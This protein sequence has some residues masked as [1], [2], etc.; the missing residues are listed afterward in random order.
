MLTISV[1]LSGALLLMEFQTILRKTH[2]SR[3]LRTDSRVVSAPFDESKSSDRQQDDQEEH[4]QDRGRVTPLPPA[5][6]AELSPVT[7]PAHT[8]HAGS[9]GHTRAVTVAT[10]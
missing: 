1:S 5:V 9:L 7:V 3:R 4:H 10:L 6:L 8:G 2:F